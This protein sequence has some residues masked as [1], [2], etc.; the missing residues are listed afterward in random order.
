MCRPPHPHVGT[1][2]C[3]PR[4]P[5]VSGVLD[6]LG[7]HPPTQFRTLLN[8]GMP[9]PCAST[10]SSL[11]VSLLKAGGNTI[12][13]LRGGWVDESPWR[14]EGLSAAILSSP[15]LPCVTAGEAI[16]RDRCGLAIPLQHRPNGTGIAVRGKLKMPGGHLRGA[17]PGVWS[18][19]GRKL[20]LKNHS[21]PCT[22]G[23]SHDTYRM[24]TA[25]L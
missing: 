17:V 18:A 5:V 3:Q 15:D 6:S 20:L 12:W 11:R 9:I 21:R 2:G 14:S 10:C 24:V 22:Y 25:M 23:A 1:L 16:R 13:Q 4:N 7:P 8:V 19:E